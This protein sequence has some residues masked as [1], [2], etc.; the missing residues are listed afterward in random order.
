MS[1][2]I[3]NEFRID[4][5][6]DVIEWQTLLSGA[7]IATLEGASGD[8]AWTFSGSCSWNPRSGA[9]AT[10][11]DLAITRA[12]GAEIFATLADGTVVELP[13]DADRY[14]LSLRFTVDGGA[15]DFAAAAGMVEADG[16]LRR[17]GFSLEIRVDL[18]AS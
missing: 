16:R 4:V 17:Q 12:D 18:D 8:G 5:A 3:T 10:E 2:V 6:G 1:Y 13:S 11:G 15:G 9:D 7:Q 14:R